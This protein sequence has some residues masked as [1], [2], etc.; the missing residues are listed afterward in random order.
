MNRPII[1]LT[2]AIVAMCAFTPSAGAVE[3]A[4]IERTRMQVKMLDDL[5]KTAVVLIT[6]HYVKDPSILSAATAAKA[7][8]S[9]MRDK[10]WH[11]AR[12]VGL[13]GAYYNPENAPRDAFEKAAAEKIRAG[14]AGHESVV[15]ENG[16]RY[17][18]MAT[19]LPVVM[20][21]CTMCHANFKDEPGNIGSLMYKVPML[22]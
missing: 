10:G 19:P 22:E 3:D 21:K 7:L 6:E 1:A 5:Y 20:E 18:R 14:A 12:L 2:G 15:T 8:F 17:L 4:A 13:L 9:S 11:D 16:T